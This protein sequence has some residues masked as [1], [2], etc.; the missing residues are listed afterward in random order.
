MDAAQR[1][2]LFWVAATSAR[3]S[4]ASSLAA[5]SQDV[6]RCVWK[7]AVCPTKLSPCYVY[8][9]PCS[10]VSARY[11]TFWSFSLPLPPYCA[12]T[13][14]AAPALP[15]PWLAS[16][17]RPRSSSTLLLLAAAALSLWFFA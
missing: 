4:P 11:K 5:P 15:M 14:S 17:T 3:D 8:D 6:F 9:V 12:S 1:L 7:Y 2:Q 10:H 13:A 16:W